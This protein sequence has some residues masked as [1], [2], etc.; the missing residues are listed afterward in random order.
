MRESPLRGSICPRVVF[1]F[2]PLDKP[3]QEELAYLESLLEGIELKEPY[4]YGILEKDPSQ[5]VKELEKLSPASVVC[6]KCE[7]LPGSVRGSLTSLCSNL[8]SEIEKDELSLKAIIQVLLEAKKNCEEYVRRTDYKLLFDL[9]QIQDFLLWAKREKYWAVDIETTPFPPYHK[10]FKV[11]SIAFSNQ[12]NNAYGFG[13]YHPGSP[14]L[15]ENYKDKQSEVFYL[16]LSFL[17]NP[18]IHWIGHNI[19]KFDK[20]G[21]EL[22]LKILM[23]SSY[24][25]YLDRFEDT[26]VMKYTLDEACKGRYKLKVCAREEL[27]WKNW[28]IDTTDLSNE[29]LDKVLKYN[30][31]DADATY[32]LYH[33]FLRKFKQFS[34][35][36]RVDLSRLYKEVHLPNAINAALLDSNG[37]KGDIDYGRNLKDNHEK[38]IR[39][40]EKK[41]LS[42]PDVVKTQTEIRKSLISKRKRFPIK[43]TPAYTKFLKKLEKESQF[44]VHSKDQIK[45]LLY[46]NLK[47]TYPEQFGRTEKKKEERVTEEVLAWH[48]EGFRNSGDTR[49][50]ILCE[51]L[52]KIQKLQQDLSN[53]IVPVV[54]NSGKTSDGLSHA[55]FSSVRVETGRYGCTNAD[56]VTGTKAECGENLQ[57]ID[58]RPDIRNLY[59][60]RFED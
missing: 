5:I 52:Y 10:Q 54:V 25:D 27:G 51:S 17:Q 44:N 35:H 38:E 45:K 49:L 13:V 31:Q 18:D 46:R 47:L 41:V 48:V 59:K 55:S 24:D 28:G 32:Q 39:Q 2:P 8:P 60:S 14:F 58:K 1:L 40:L 6:F 37:I 12:N 30:C 53:F 57:K 21:M 22:G 43:G 29:P 34:S 56:D 20:V 36:Y 23:S 19:L 3:I 16:F 7:L 15:G 9:Q 26:M 11:L 50:L 33:V 4:A 42:D